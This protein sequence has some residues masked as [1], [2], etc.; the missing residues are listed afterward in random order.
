[1]SEQLYVIQTNEEIQDLIDKLNSPE[2][3]GFVA[4][5]TETTGLDQDAEII[6]LSVSF[7]VEV[8]YYILRSYWDVESKKL[9]RLDNMDKVKEL[10]TVLTT[11]NLV[12]HNATV[13][14][15]WTFR[16]FGIQLKE[17]LHT[18]TMV[19]A[20]LLDENR[21]V[22]L[23][24]LG[25][26]EFGED[27]K[28]EASEM[29]ES[30]INNLGI[31]QDKRGGAKEMYKADW[32]IIGMYGA[33]D[34]LLTFKL[35]TVMVPKLLEAKLDTFFYDEESMPLFK[36]PTYD[37]NT[38][39]LKVDMTA[40]K[41]LQ[42]E[43]TVEIARLKG[44]ILFDITP[45]IKD[46][47]PATKITNTFNIGSTQ[48]MSWLLFVKLENEWKKLTKSGRTDARE[49]MGKVPYT[50]TAKKAYMNALLQGAVLPGAK[51]DK[52]GN[53][54]IAKPIQPQK[55]I[56]CDKNVLMNFQ[57][58]Y[59]WVEKLLE[60]N[61]LQKLLKTYVIG[62]Q[63]F[64]NYG[65][66][67]PSFNQTGT[68]GT[69]YSS[70]RPNFQNLPRKDKRVKKCIISRPGKVF[71]GADYS[72]LEPRVFASFAQ[73]ERLLNCFKEGQDFYSVVGIPIFRKFEC[74][75][76]K[77]GHPQAFGEKYPALR[78]LAKGTALS[79]A[80]GTGAYKLSELLRDK[81]GKNLTV[82]EC[83]QIIEDYFTAYPAVKQY[84]LRQHEQVKNHGV[85]Y[86]LFGRPRRIP[87]ALFINKLGKDLKAEDLPY[88]YR[89]L[90]NLAVNNPIQNTAGSIV[91]RAAIAFKR[92][93]ASIGIEAPIVLQVHDE[94]V[95]ECNEEDAE[96]V[97]EVLKD[98]METTV[99]LPGVDLVAEPK[100][101]KNLADLK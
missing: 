81:D 12:M 16:N 10:L 52:D 83:T 34:A 71:V 86:N 27:A 87:E 98:A 48:Q 85:V 11:K 58:K 1:M 22:G 46:K 65:V 39:G 51:L 56:Q 78:D 93:I 7:N 90:L 60:Y 95:V 96:I 74:V 30:V 42:D 40:L 64:I 14:C 43:L 3:E 79:A 32:K 38:T 88:E 76:L 67:Y 53:P 75:P 97:K 82:E 54:P 25:I 21:S 28:K 20:H 36:G 66:I 33:K 91:N 8:G 89:T 17:S 68:A 77:E 59:L 84:Q 73:D 69:R 44:E 19:L 45:Y 92:N 72:Q 100:I 31:W 2:C 37:L 15:N 55:Y 24:E 63:R 80:Y 94:L 9:I 5:D 101:A 61:R 99:V 49:R 23:K 62:L 41:K 70:S 29:K 6:G 4:Y 35:F 50:W 18:D 47:F 13:D 26:V 57:K